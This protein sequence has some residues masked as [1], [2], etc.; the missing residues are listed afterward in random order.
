[1]SVATRLMDQYSS[2]FYLEDYRNEQRD[3]LNKLI[4]RKAKGLPL[5][6]TST[7]S[8]YTTPENEVVEKMKILLDESP[9]TLGG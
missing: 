6:K 7:I 4:E 3:H 8:E 2:M 9:K 5:R 1:V